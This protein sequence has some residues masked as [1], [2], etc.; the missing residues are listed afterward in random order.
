[1]EG[2]GLDDTSFRDNNINLLI[3]NYK[4]TRLR[5]LGEVRFP[6]APGSI[7]GTY[8]CDGL[9]GVVWGNETGGCV[10][11]GSFGGGGGKKFRTQVRC[12]DAHVRTLVEGESRGGWVIR[13]FCCRI[14]D[15]VRGIVLSERWFP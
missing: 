8:S 1:M 4:Y 15:G 7:K 6:I 12:S 9:A 11:V 13:H 14:F 10:A 3:T 5:L 2:L